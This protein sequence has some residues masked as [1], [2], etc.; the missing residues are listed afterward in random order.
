MGGRSSEHEVSLGSARSVVAGL[1]PERYD[2]LSIHIP[3]E[4][5]W[6]PGAGD[7]AGVDV[8][9]PVLHGPFGEDG[10][11]QGLLEL[12]DVAYVGAG[13]TASAL[14]MDKDLFKSVLR[15]KGIPVA[16]SIALRPGNDA[17][18]H[19]YRLRG[20]A[21]DSAGAFE[22]ALRD[23][24]HALAVARRSGDVREQWQ[25]LLDLGALWAARDYRRAG[26]YCREAVDLARSMGDSTALGHALNRLGNWH[27]NAE[28]PNESLRYHHEAL[29]IFEGIGD[30]QGLASTLD[31]IGVV[32]AMVGHVAQGLRY[33]ERAIPLL[34]QLDDL[35]TLSSALT[36]AAGVASGTWSCQAVPRPTMPDSLGAASGVAHEAIQVARD[37]GW[38]AGE[39]FALLSASVAMV[40]RGDVRAGL[41]GLYNALDIADET[42]GRFYD[43]SNTSTL[44]DDLRYTGRGVTTVEEHELWHLPIVLLLLVGLLCAEWGYRRVVGLA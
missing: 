6:L 17:G 24:E 38:R 18:P 4:G 23:Y 3:R 11:V 44:A 26:A 16:R 10:T 9:F 34:R 36:N 29:E 31:L 13:V 21:H 28:R 37:I 8:V 41:Q 15:D 40:W 43:P 42:G 25:S 14:A 20:W 7:L 39:A 19:V 27:L 32:Y 12:A 22:Q 5:P 33:F 2:V 35:Q 30:R 1:D